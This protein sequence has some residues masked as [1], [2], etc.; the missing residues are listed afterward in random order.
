VRRVAAA[1][2]LVLAAAC[3]APASATCAFQ[4][5]TSM[6]FT[7]GGLGA[8]AATAAAT[9]SV[10]CDAASASNVS[11][12]IDPGL[13][14]GGSANPSRR[15]LNAANDQTLS[16]NIFIDGAYT[17]IWGDGTNGT[18]VQSRAETAGT[19]SLTL[20][21]LIPSGQHVPAGTYGDVLT[22]TMIF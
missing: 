6:Q 4:N 22:A 1:L 10:S 8:G 7:Y 16:Y 18:V 20:Y 3:A 13:H 11:I 9:M 21:G 14:A 15:L 5:I 12:A 2:A 17:T 19:F